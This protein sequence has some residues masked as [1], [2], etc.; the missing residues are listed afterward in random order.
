MTTPIVKK[1]KDIEMIKFPSKTLILSGTEKGLNRYVIVDDLFR[2]YGSPAS[3][4]CGRGR[5]RYDV[6]W[7]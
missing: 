4:P 6:I 2:C 1:A 7:L 5:C 3:F